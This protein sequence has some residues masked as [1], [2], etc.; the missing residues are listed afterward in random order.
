MAIQISETSRA[1]IWL[2]ALEMTQFDLCKHLFEIFPLSM[3]ET[4]T[5]PP[6][7]VT[8]GLSSGELRMP[9]Q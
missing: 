9:K 3:D 4:D 5:E 6:R 8:S 1:Y 7:I 2:I